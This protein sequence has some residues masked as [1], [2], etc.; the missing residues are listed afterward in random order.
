MGYNNL[1]ITE[2]KELAVHMMIEWLRVYDR[3][4]SEEVGEVD[5]CGDIYECGNCGAFII[6]GIESDYRHDLATD[7]YCCGSCR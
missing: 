6:P 1:D 4:N 3:V 7:K 5:P 2:C